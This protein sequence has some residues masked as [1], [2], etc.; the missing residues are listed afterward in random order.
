M[1][2]TFSQSL[3]LTTGATL[4]KYADVA[5]DAEVYRNGLEAL[6]AAI[7]GK[8]VLVCVASGVLRLTRTPVYA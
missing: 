8:S 3:M 6:G 7:L 2:R 4:C 1:P 5:H